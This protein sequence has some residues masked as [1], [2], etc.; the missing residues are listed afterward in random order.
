MIILASFQSICPHLTLIMDRQARGSGESAIVIL[1]SMLFCPLI[2]DPVGLFVFLVLQCWHLDH[3]SEAPHPRCRSDM[4][5][6]VRSPLVVVTDAI[7]FH[8]DRV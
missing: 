3:D 2:D 6:K 8:A 1:I 7:Y 4:R 5:R